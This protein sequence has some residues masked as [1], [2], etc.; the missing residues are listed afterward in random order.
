MLVRAPA[1]PGQGLHHPGPQFFIFSHF[2]M[3]CGPEKLGLVDQTWLERDMSALLLRTL[4]VG[5]RHHQSE[6]I[7]VAL[8][9]YGV[10]VDSHIHSVFVL[11]TEETTVT[12]QVIHRPITKRRYEG[13]RITSW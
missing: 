7:E 11:A 6:S 3:V 5:R 1:S 2:C 12:Q 10:V 4:A 8:D 9:I 13:Q